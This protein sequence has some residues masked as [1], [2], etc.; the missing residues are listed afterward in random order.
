[1]CSINS[2]I[3][4]LL[5]INRLIATAVQNSVSKL[6]FVC[7]PECCVFMGKSRTETVAAAEDIY[8][9]S[10]STSIKAESFVELFQRLL[11]CS[12]SDVELDCRNILGSFEGIE[13]INTMQCLCMIAAKHNIWLSV[14]GFPEIHRTEKTSES[15]GKIYNSHVIIDSNGN[16]LSPIYRKVIS[17]RVLYVLYCIQT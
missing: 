3:S 9:I 5:T 2:K 1:M 12:S 11:Q 8:P 14:G 17:I 16:I 10:T 15:T 4:N 6:D 13:S 7:L